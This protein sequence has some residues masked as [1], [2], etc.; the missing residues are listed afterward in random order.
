MLGP[1]IDLTAHIVSGLAVVA[2]ADGLVVGI[3]QIGQGEDLGHIDRMP[4]GRL[5]L[6]QGLIPE[7]AALDHVHHIEPGADDTIVHAQ[8]VGP[9]HRKAGRIEGR[10]DLVFPVH[11]VG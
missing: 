2:Q 6:R 5:V 3:V 10:D 1:S 7:D 4:L 8:T 9:R 11:G